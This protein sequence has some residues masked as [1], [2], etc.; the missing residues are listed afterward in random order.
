VHC[1]WDATY[2]AHLTKQKSSIGWGGVQSR[3]V[4]IAIGHLWGRDL[5]VKKNLTI[6]QKL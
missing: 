5:L 6:G 4:C 3:P 2:T 1:V